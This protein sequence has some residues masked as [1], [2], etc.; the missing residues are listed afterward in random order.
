MPLEPMPL[1]SVDHARWYLDALTDDDTVDSLV[2]PLFEAYVRILHPASADDG[3]PVRWAEVAAEQGTTL[4]PS[5]RFDRLAGRGRHGRASG[6]RGDDP[7][8]GSL[9]RE[10]LETLVGVLAAHTATPGTVWLSLWNGFGQLPAAWSDRPL[11]EEGRG[12]RDYHAFRC[13][14]DE[15][16]ALSRRFDGIG[17][18][19][20][21]GPQAA[22]VVTAEFFGEGDPEAGLPARHRDERHHDLQSPQ[23]WW[24]DDRSWAV[25]TEIDDEHT[26][27]A[28]SEALIEALLAHPELETVSVEAR[29]ELRDTVNRRPTR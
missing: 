5:A 22:T 9:D 1:D 10:T 7:Y 18:E 4:H 17:W 16:V 14:L 24:P 28:G 8:E 15:V 26:V 13:A 23:Q 25:A 21:G 2:P 20:A 19:D 27:V 29:T 11:V 12:Y 3:R 6:W